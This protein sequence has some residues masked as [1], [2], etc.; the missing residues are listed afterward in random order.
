MPTSPRGGRCPF[1]LGRALP[2]GRSAAPDPRSLA[3][4]N[5]FYAST[6]MQWRPASKALSGM[7]HF[8]MPK[9]SR[10]SCRPSLCHGQLCSF[11]ACASLRRQHMAQT[12]PARELDFDACATSCLP[13]D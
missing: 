3:S 9:L 11:D 1:H 8:V 13:R 4:L 12:S 7:T 10:R 6:S 2:S 5:P